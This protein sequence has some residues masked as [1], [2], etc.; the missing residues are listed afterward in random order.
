M[1]THPI[2]GYLS[3]TFGI[4]DI[5]NCVSSF[6][7]GR[8][9]EALKFFCFGG[10][11]IG[12]FLLFL[13]SGYKLKELFNTQENLKIK[14]IENNNSC[15]IKSFNK[16]VQNCHSLIVE[17]FHLKIPN[18]VLLNE[19]CRELQ[20]QSFKCENVN[21]HVARYNSLQNYAFRKAKFEIFTDCPADI[22]SFHL[23]NCHINFM[24]AFLDDF[25]EEQYQSSCNQLTSMLHRCHN[26]NNEVQKYME[27]IESL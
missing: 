16:V 21:E 7:N 4:R 15:D 18:E 9:F 14:I 1:S 6:R 10:I 20:K 3:R 12:A 22:F 23:R 26:E 17:V 11:K 13:Y 2:Y 5:Q 24:K 8:K 19:A 25:S 27:F